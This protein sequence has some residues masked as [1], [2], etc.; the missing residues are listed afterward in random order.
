M[1]K[2]TLIIICALCL[3]VQTASG[4][5]TEFPLLKMGAGGRAIAMG[6]AFTGVADDASSVFWNPAGMAQ[7]TNTFTL[8]FTNRLHYQSSNFVEFFGT[9]SDIKYGSF[10]FGVLSNQIDD[11]I[12]TDIDRN[13]LG[14]FGAYQRAIMFSYAYNLTPVYVGFSLSSVQSGM[15]PQQGD[16]SGNGFTMGLGLMT[17][18]TKNFKIGSIIR[19]GY[20]IKFDDS[21]DDIPGGTRLGAEFEMKTGWT[22]DGDSLRIVIDLD[23]TNRLPMKVKTGIELIFMDMIAL[24]GGINSL[25]IETRTEDLEH[26]DLMSANM[27]FSFGAGIKFSLSDSGIFNLDVG[28]ISTELGNST[29]L[30]ISWTK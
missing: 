12:E 8:S 21:K 28:V 19:P 1:I 15:D 7:L 20:S 26:S 16:I 30:T 23:Q 4:G 24:R 14:T 25:M 2:K 6:G 9:Y 17:R 27:K 18:V 29:V 10:G 13:H 5:E 3:I 11:I 22:S